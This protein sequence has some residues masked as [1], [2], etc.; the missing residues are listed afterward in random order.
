MRFRHVTCFDWWERVGTA[1]DSWNL[2]DFSRVKDRIE[3][4]YMHSKDLDPSLVGPKKTQR[5]LGNV[6]SS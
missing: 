5:F 4:V 1:G 2:M 3:Y 6:G